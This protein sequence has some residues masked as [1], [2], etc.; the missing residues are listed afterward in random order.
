[1]RKCLRVLLA[2]GYSPMKYF[3]KDYKKYFY[4]AELCSLVD[5]SLVRCTI[6]MYAPLSVPHAFAHANLRS[7]GADGEDRRPVQPMGRE[8]YEP[9]H[10]K[11]S[12]AV[13]RR[14]RHLQA[15]RCAAVQVKQCSAHGRNGIIHALSDPACPV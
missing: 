9:G 2:A 11:T 6:F 10:R 8:R 12:Q 3:N 5:L 15:A 14:H 1:M 4:L 7:L 13:L